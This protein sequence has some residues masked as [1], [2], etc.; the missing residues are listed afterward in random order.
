MSSFGTVPSQPG[1]VPAFDFNADDAINGLD[2]G[3]FRDRY[4]N[5]LQP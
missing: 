1:Y 2:L 4:G 3:P 5:T